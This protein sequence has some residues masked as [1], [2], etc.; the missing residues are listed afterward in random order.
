MKTKE[1]KVGR[2]PQDTEARQRKLSNQSHAKLSTLQEMLAV[3]QET[4]GMVNTGHLD[5]LW[6]L[7]GRREVQKQHPEESGNELTSVP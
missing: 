6:S 5:I 2:P 4:R 7:I 1:R 3:R